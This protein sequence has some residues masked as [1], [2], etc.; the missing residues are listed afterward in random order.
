MKKRRASGERPGVFAETV[1]RS[2]GRTSGSLAAAV[3]GDRGE[4]VRAGR[5]DRREA[6][7]GGLEVVLA[8]LGD[9]AD[10]LAVAVLGARIILAGGAHFLAAAVLLEERLAAGI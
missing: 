1:C 7:A 2:G 10:G 6:V 4:D 3:D 5:V 8:A 9:V